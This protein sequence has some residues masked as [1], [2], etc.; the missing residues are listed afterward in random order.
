VL[1]GEWFE[2]GC[3]LVC[4]KGDQL[5]K[6]IKIRRSEYEYE[7]EYE[8]GD[9]SRRGVLVMDILVSKWIECP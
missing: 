3:T 2:A 1:G 5:A 8:Y 6:M 7:Y 9:L 4:I